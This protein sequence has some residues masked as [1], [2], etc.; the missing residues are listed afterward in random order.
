MS[1]QLALRSQNMNACQA[2]LVC[3]LT[4][5]LITSLILICHH[6]YSL[7]NVTLTRSV[8]IVLL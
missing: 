5:V 2:K 8:S 7:G 3:L 1:Q 6:S 4:Q